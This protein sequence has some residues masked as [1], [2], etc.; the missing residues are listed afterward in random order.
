[1][2]YIRLMAGVITLFTGIGIGIDTL[3]KVLTS[4]AAAIDA[5]VVTIMAAPLAFTGVEAIRY[6]RHR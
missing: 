2:F 3:I 6:A 1:M 5:V 4:D